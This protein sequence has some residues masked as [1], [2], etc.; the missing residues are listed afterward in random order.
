MNLQFSSAD[1]LNHSGD[2]TQHDIIGALINALQRIDAL[3]K[4][5]EGARRAAE[6]ASCIANGIKPD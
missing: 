2:V 1:Y 3:E 6:T 4:K 5:L